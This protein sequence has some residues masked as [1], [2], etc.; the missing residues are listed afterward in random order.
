[1]AKTRKIKV[2]DLEKE[3]SKILTEYAGDVSEGMKK[4]VL[5]VAKIAKQETQ[6]GAPVRT[7]VYQK[8]W[9]VKEQ[10]WDRFR[11][12]AIV[13]STNRYQIAHLLEKGHALRNGGRTRA[14]PHIGPAEQNAAKNLEKAVK[15]VVEKI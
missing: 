11:I 10:K 7:G 9:A 2:D 13:H 14:I 1:M 4:A 5:T 8:S 3:V 12:D 6:S 15:E